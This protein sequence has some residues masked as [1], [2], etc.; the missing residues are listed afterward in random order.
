M[1]PILQLPSSITA[2]LPPATGSNEQAATGKTPQHSQERVSPTTV[3]P[4]HE[5]TTNLTAEAD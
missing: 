4:E 3:E 1:R 5:I 2:N